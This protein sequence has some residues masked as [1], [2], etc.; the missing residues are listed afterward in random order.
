MAHERGLSE[1][2]YCG[3]HE[4]VVPY[5]SVFD[6]GFILSDSIETI[7]FAARE[8]MSMGKPLISSSFSGLK[9]NFIHEING[10]LINQKDIRSLVSAM[11][12]FLDM[13]KHELETFSKKAREYAVDHFDIGIQKIGIYYCIITYYYKIILV[14]SFLI[15]CASKI[16]TL[17]PSCTSSPYI[18]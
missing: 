17:L 8:M 6:V 18:F 15:I 13:D 12:Y 2:I 10:I 1:F 4:D 3:F 7:S 5:V 14:S 16:L 11:K 9:E